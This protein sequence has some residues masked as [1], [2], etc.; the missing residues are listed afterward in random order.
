M[1][2]RNPTLENQTSVEGGG[3]HQLAK[4]VFSFGTSVLP[5]FRVGEQLQFTVEPFRLT[6]LARFLFPN[7]GKVSSD[8]SIVVSR[9]NVVVKELPR[10]QQAT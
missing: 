5:S 9:N 8:F 7:F 10:R 6:V 2:H 1:N 3:T 4:A